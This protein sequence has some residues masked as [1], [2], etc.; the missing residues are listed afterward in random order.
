[1]FKDQHRIAFETKHD[2]QLGLQK[3]AVDLHAGG[4]PLSH[5]RDIKPKHV[6][7]LL[8]TWQQNGLGQGTIKNRLSQ[9]RYL[10]EYIKKPTLLPKSNAEMNVAKRS[11]MAKES[12]AIHYIDPSHFENTLIRYSVQ[13]QQHFGLRRE[14]SIKF[15]VSYA[16]QGNH[17]RLKDSWTKG[18]IA[19][20][21]PITTEAQRT[22]LNEIKSII[23]RGHSLIPTDKTYGSQRKIYDAAV[24]TSGYK[25]LHGLRHAYAQ[26]RYFEITQQLSGQGWHPPFNGGPSKKTLLPHQKP[27]DEEARLIISHELGHSRLQIAGVYLG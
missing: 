21:I 24:Q 22:L 20:T 13:L 1:M 18:G 10:A 12:K 19:R 15:I 25:N 17:I 6:E 7:Y 14:E 23:G 4:Y 5:I 27:I 3:M 26:R 2:Y 11:Y 8:K 16:D 9:V